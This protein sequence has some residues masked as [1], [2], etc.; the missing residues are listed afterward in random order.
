MLNLSYKRIISEDDVDIP[1][2]IAIYK[3]PEIV[4]YISIS[5]SYFRYVTE[6]DE[7]YFYKI[8]ESNKL[9]GTIHI[10]KQGI[11]LF[12]D[13]LVFP[14]FQ[15]MGLGTKI[16]KDIQDDIFGLHFERIEISIDERNTASLKLFENAGFIRI[17]KDDKLINLT[18]H[19]IT[20]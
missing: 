3:K 11:A 1:N 14:E 4:Q 20:A 10:E 5:E 8:Y 18:Y 19:R 15:R 16:L 7:V 2:L 12:M 17:S 13:I 9:I 6:N